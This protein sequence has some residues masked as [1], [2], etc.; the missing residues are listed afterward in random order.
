MFLEIFHFL[1]KIYTVVQIRK[2]VTAIWFSKAVYSEWDD[3]LDLVG[4][5]AEDHPL[6]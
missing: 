6:H 4:C 5:F 1:C 3:D 2:V